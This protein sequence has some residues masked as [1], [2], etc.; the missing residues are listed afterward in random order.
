MSQIILIRPK[1]TNVKHIKA[2]TDRCLGIENHTVSRNNVIFVSIGTIAITV[3]GALLTT[4]FS[5][6]FAPLSEG[7]KDTIS[8]TPS[9]I[10]VTAMTFNNDNKDSS[11][12][13]NYGDTIA[14]NSITF[15]FTAVQPSFLG[16]KY[17]PSFQCS[18]DGAPFEDCVPP[19][20]YGNLPT[21][22][23]HSFQVRA[24]GILGN[25]EQ[26][27]DKFY[28]TAITSASVEGVIKRNGTAEGDA[29]IRLDSNLT[30]LL[31]WFEHVG[32]L[33]NTT[34]D[35]NS[36][37]HTTITDSRG[38]FQFEGLGQGKH[39][40]VINSTL[41]KK[42]YRDNFF[43]PAGEQLKELDDFEILEMSP[44]TISSLGPPRDPNANNSEF[45][46]T[47]DTTKLK[48][49]TI[50]L[51]QETKLTPKGPNTFLTKVWLNAPQNILAEVVNM[52]YY[53]HP[54]FNPSV[55]TA[56]TAENKFS[57]SFT[58]WG[59]FDLKAKVYFKDGTIQELVLPMNE[60]NPPKS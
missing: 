53:L 48:N 30:R 52:T 18:F 42:P 55:I 41:E 5:P 37:L 29:I 21:E 35:S 3:V 10:N 47:E 24:K 44:V 40:F 49:Y 23:G 14:S 22:V 46:G 12:P 2:H 20:S 15:N 34:S 26:S 11:K 33:T 32:R 1:L 58:N 28:F 60:W 56:Y 7:I 51:E 43:V 57:I 6:V 36:D 27:P 59:I 31:E 8:G 9:T 38:R 4:V 39:N 50:D 19:I 16:I 45:K 17:S 54:T 13:V 25:L